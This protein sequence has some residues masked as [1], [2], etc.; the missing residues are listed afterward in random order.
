MNLITWCTPL[1]WRAICVEHRTLAS[2]DWCVLWHH[3]PCI[4]YVVILHAE[5]LATTL[6]L[7]DLLG[8]IYPSFPPLP[9]P[10]VGGYAVRSSACSAQPPLVGGYAVQPSGRSA[11]SQ[12]G[13]YHQLHPF[14][15]NQESAT[16]Y[17]LCVSCLT[18]LCL[19][20]GVL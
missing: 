17:K 9:P 15:R 11:Q 5:F 16:I 2:P 20:Q 14:D 6:P 4:L 10:P 18:P 19:G 3:P 8:L 13:N 12:P 7:P 1:F